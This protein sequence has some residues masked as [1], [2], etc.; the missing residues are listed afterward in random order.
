MRKKGFI[1]KNGAQL[2]SYMYIAKYDLCLCQ[3]IHT[4]N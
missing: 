3:I 1:L 4:Q 2:H